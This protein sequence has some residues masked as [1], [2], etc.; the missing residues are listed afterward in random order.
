MADKTVLLKVGLTA[1]LMVVWLAASTE[2][3][4]E[5][6]WAGWTVVSK[7]LMKAARK[8]VAKVGLMESMTDIP[9]AV[10]WVAL[11]VIWKAATMVEWTVDSKA[12]TKA[13]LMVH[14]LAG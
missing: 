12:A 2:R 9:M 1:A 7:A 8:A 14:S 3:S 13:D 5:L 4:L 11:M 10:K 6:N